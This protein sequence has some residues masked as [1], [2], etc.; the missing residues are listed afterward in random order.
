MKI[1]ELIRKEDLGEPY[2]ALSYILDMSEILKIEQLYRGR[3]IWFRKWV[4]DVEKEYKE[5]VAA[6]GREK[7]KEVI[8]IFGGSFVYFPM[9]SR[10]CS[11]KI[12]KQI[13]SEFNGVNYAELAKN[14]GYSERS[15]RRI[16][17]DKGRKKERTIDGQLNIF[18]ILGKINDNDKTNK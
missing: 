13:K 18:D 15:I 6:I 1:E 5:L 2:A 7:T 12:K 11:E 8:R 16:T 4:G 10:A 3:Q 17:G 14:Y 9:L